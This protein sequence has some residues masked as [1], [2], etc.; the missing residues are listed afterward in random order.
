MSVEP[1]WRGMMRT[2]MR[3]RFIDAAAALLLV[4]A[5]APVL[6]EPFPD[7]KPVEMTVMFGAGSA[8]DVTARYLADGM[9]T[10]LG[11]PVP[12]VN[13][14][15]GGGA[16]GYSHVSKQKPDGHSI[17]WNSNSVSTNYHSGIMS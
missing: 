10:V 14:T 1:W 15:G 6:A 12:V 13:R 3:S 11:V 4:A 5:A 16:I 2:I 7:R 8:A 9:A 17:L